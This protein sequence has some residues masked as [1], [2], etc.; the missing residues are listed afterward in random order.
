MTKSLGR[1][2]CRGQIHKA[3]FKQGANKHEYLKNKMR[4][5]RSTLKLR[6]RLWSWNRFL[7]STWSV[8]GLM[9]AT[10]KIFQTK[11]K[12]CFF[13]SFHFEEYFFK[14]ILLIV[15]N[16]TISKKY[17]NILRQSWPLSFCL[18][19]EI[20]VS[21]RD[22][23][24]VFHDKG[25]L[26]HVPFLDCHHRSGPDVARTSRTVWANWPLGF[27]ESHGQHFILR[28]KKKRINVEK[29]NKA[30]WYINIY[31]PI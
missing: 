8:T 2:P 15:L 7:R 1:G 27:L 16:L 3:K 28:C 10:E 24:A 11:L 6:A 21:E 4:T 31:L 12:P 30:D 23:Y 5:Q 25:S 14:I 22:L 20:F 9:S 13:Y 19:K 17:L 18:K 26:F 29:I